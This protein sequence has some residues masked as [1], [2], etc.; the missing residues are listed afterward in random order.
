MRARSR[1]R[2]VCSD[3]HQTKAGFFHRNRFVFPLEKIPLISNFC[4]RL[5]FEEFIV[6]FSLFCMDPGTPEKVGMCGVKIVV[7][8]DLYRVVCIGFLKGYYFLLLNN[9]IFT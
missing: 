3:T 2:I 8:I 6:S 7:T 9:V 5:L 1:G 4:K